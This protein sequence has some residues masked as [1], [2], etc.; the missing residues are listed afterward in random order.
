MM[1]MMPGMFYSDT[2]SYGAVSPAPRASANSS[3]VFHRSAGFVRIAFMMACWTPADTGPR[4]VL[5]GAGGVMNFFAITD[6]GE[7]P[8]KGGPPAIISYVTHASE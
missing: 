4:I 8:M 5:R 3:T 6:R 7:A 1:V 2:G